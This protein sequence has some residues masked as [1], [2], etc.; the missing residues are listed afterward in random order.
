M[1]LSDTQQREY[2]ARR[3]AAIALRRAG[4]SAK[5]TAEQLGTNA[6]QV[7][8]L[9]EGAD[10]TPPPEPAPDARKPGPKRQPARRKAP[11]QFRD[12]N[13]NL[14]AMLQPFT[15]GGVGGFDDP[16]RIQTGEIGPEEAGRPT[17]IVWVE[18]GIRRWSYRV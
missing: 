14:G 2:D 18:D 9:T 3:D 1:P 15:V 11:R 16:D 10:L 12:R 13:K 5:Q 4:L 17:R 6:R 8:R 7:R